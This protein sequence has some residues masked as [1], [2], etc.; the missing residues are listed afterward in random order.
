MKQEKFVNDEEKIWSPT[1]VTR[2][3]T[4]KMYNWALECTINYKYF[5]IKYNIISEYKHV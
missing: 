3:K 5:K 2:N 1:L 4:D